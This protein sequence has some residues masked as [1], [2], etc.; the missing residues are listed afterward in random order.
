MAISSIGCKDY[1]V[2]PYTLVI[3]SIL[4]S[5]AYRTDN[6]LSAIMIWEPVVIFYIFI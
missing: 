5:I 6:I 1:F 2:D 3:S 4:Y